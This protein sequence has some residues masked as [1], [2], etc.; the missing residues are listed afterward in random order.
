[1]RSMSE[2]LFLC[3]S[4]KSAVIASLNIVDD[5]MAGTSQG[6]DDEVSSVKFPMIGLVSLIL[7]LFLL[8]AI[9]LVIFIN[10]DDP[11]FPG[12]CEVTRRTFC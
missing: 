5:E 6:S 11:C 7:L 12:D 2:I 10:V 3:G 9:V 1:M 8:H 4:N